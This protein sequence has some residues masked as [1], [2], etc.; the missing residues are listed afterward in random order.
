MHTYHAQDN[1]KLI[2]VH[3]TQEIVKFTQK[4][5]MYKKHRAHNIHIKLGWLEEHRQCPI[6]L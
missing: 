1:C 5:H 3:H 4:P 2:N 6:R